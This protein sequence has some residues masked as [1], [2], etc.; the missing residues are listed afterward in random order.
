MRDGALAASDSSVHA[1]PGGANVHLGRGDPVSDDPT[2]VPA[3]PADAWPR[4]ALA[5]V[6]AAGGVARAHRPADGAPALRE[7]QP[8][9]VRGQSLIASRHMRQP[10]ATWN[11][12]SLRVK[13]EDKARS[14]KDTRSACDRAARLSRRP[15]A[16]IANKRDLDTGPLVHNGRPGR[17]TAP[18]RSASGRLERR[19]R[20]SN[21]RAAYRR[22]TVFKT[23]AFNR[24]ATPPARIV[25]APS[26][27]RLTLAPTPA[28]ARRCKG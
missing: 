22:L 1:R 23:V 27:C 11:E 5:R 2:P 28:R 19:G 3:A 25:P 26:T 9:A 24:S 18:I 13:A 16:P 20:D 4:T 14:S 6:G 15:R 12:C 10:A 7:F 21:P 17:R 8:R